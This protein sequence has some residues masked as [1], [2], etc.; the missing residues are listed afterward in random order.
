MST[1]H[2]VAGTRTYVPSN[3]LVARAPR[4]E[5]APLP[6]SLAARACRVAFRAVAWTGVVIVAVPAQAS[7]ASASAEIELRAPTRR[8]FAEIPW[9]GVR[10]TAEPTPVQSTTSVRSIFDSFAWEDA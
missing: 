5:I 8:V 6:P 9:T 7:I 10:E 2:S 4:D 1:S 3:R